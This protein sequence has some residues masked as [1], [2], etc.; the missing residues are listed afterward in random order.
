MLKDEGTHIDV[1]KIRRSQQAH[2]STKNDI[3]NYH[4]FEFLMKYAAPKFS[5][6]RFLA[7]MHGAY[8]SCGWRREYSA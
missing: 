5:L 3:G 2:F 4:L 8:W 1:D 6:S 7:T